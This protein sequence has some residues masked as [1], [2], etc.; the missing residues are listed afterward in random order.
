MVKKIWLN[1]SYIN[2]K[3]VAIIVYIVDRKYTPPW[4]VDRGLRLWSYVDDTGRASCGP[5]ITFT[6]TPYSQRKRNMH[7]CS[8]IWISGRLGL[9]PVSKEIMTISVIKIRRFVDPILF[10]VWISKLIRLHLSLDTD[11]SIISWL[12][13]IDVNWYCNSKLRWKYFHFKTIKYTQ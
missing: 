10:F 8:S 13:K 3:F 12:G 9:I 4:V 2:C 5:G 6:S 7:N 11:R 1:H